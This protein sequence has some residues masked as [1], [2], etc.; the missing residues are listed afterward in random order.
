MALREYRARYHQ[1]RLGMAWAVI[2]PVLLMIVFTAFVRR[3]TTVDTGDI[4]YPV[5]SYLG[6]IP[7]SFFSKIGRAHV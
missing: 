2:T 3:V 4:P 6:L 7:W 5:F 1:T